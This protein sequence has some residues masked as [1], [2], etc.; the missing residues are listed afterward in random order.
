[1][2]KSYLLKAAIC[3]AMANATSMFAENETVTNIG[4]ISENMFS[5]ESMFDTDPMGAIVKFKANSAEI[6]RKGDDLIDQ[7]SSTLKAEGFVD[8]EDPTEARLEVARV[9]FGPAMVNKAVKDG[10]TEQ[11][12]TM[13]GEAGSS[14]ATTMFALKATDGVDK[15]INTKYEDNGFSMESMGGYDYE[16][17]SMEH[18]DSFDPEAHTSVSMLLSA[19]S[20]IESPVVR[21]N[22]PAYKLPPSKNVI[23]LTLSQEYLIGNDTRGGKGQPFAKEDIPL[24]DSYFRSDLWL[25]NRLDCIPVYEEASKSYFVDKTLTGTKS[26]QDELGGTFKRGYLAFGK[27]VDLISIA[28]SRGEIKNR[29]QDRTDQLDP[30]FSLNA[31]IVKVYDVSAPSTAQAFTLPVGHFD[32]AESFKESQGGSREF[33]ITFSEKNIRS[34]TPRD[35]TDVEATPELLE[36]IIAAYPGGLAF[37]AQATFSRID[38]TS[39][40]VNPMGNIVVTGAYTADNKFVPADDSTLAPMLS[41]IGFTADGYDLNLQRTDTNFSNSGKE[42]EVNSTTKRYKVG[43]SPRIQ[44][45]NPVG[46]SSVEEARLLDSSLRKITREKVINKLKDK[47]EL[48][49]EYTGG[50][51]AIAEGVSYPSRAFGDIVTIPTLRA[52][53]YTPSQ[54]TVTRRHA[55]RMADSRGHVIGLLRTLITEATNESRLKTVAKDLNK[56][57]ED[58]KVNITVDPRINQL[59]M[60]EGDDNLLTTAFKNFEIIEDEA[61][62]FKDHIFVTFSVDTPYEISPISNGIRAVGISPVV[63]FDPEQINNTKIAKT[64]A[65][66]RELIL[67]TNNIMVVV[68]V[69]NLNELM[70]V[71]KA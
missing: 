58:I 52:E 57:V 26:I 61:D 68:K 70:N 11:I 53:T 63:R 20:V 14:M 62:V 10:E 67:D 44:V 18:F 32:S 71:T 27:T 8:N 64:F 17:F 54:D 46:T 29:V 34:K 12:L 7:L 21:L 39:A 55:E 40:T 36:T 69:E 45:R 31:L 4:E 5:M 51:G 6:E 37:S 2:N 50:K 60:V 24:L 56:G 35:M 13:L 59:L 25:D 66:P 48:L 22:Y 23:E 49:M 38:L 43:F 30:A 33:S 1:M 9:L 16:G 3:T 15:L 28:G 47:Y 42:V 19:M 65:Q 41:A